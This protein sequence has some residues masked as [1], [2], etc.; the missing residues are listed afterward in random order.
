MA[1]NPAHIADAYRIVAGVNHYL[2][3]VDPVYTREE[4]DEAEQILITVDNALDNKDKILKIALDL[5]EHD[6][7]AL[8]NG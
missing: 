3:R 1:I 7:K 6:R 4:L 5:L 8:D 2:V